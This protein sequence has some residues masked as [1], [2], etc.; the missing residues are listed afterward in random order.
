MVPVHAR[1]VG[2]GRGSGD[3]LA[4]GAD[5]VIF[6]GG[7]PERGIDFALGLGK[8]E[9]F[10][11]VPMA[12][13]TTDFGMAAVPVHDPPRTDVPAVWSPYPNGLD[14]APIAAAGDFVARVRPR[15]REPGS[16][17][18]LEL[19]RLDAAGA[20]TSLGAVADGRRITDVAMAVDKDGAVWLLY[21]DANATF[22]ER[23]V[24]P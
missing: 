5:A 24:C 6:V 15:E 20:F 14:P 12:R 22:L 4:L 1:H 11:L 7:A 18:I 3:K 2:V 13:E 23:R 21:G 10:A 9:L 17:R 16:P 19:G 8:K